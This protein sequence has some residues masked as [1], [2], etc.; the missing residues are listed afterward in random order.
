MI[1]WASDATICHYISLIFSGISFFSSFIALFPQILQTYN[2]KSVEG[3]SFLFLSSWVLGDTVT[4]IGAI[5]TDQLTFQVILA[6]YHLS[7]DLLVCGQYYYYGILYKNQYSGLHKNNRYKFNNNKSSSNFNIFTA[8][9]GFF[10]QITRARA[11]SGTSTPVGNNDKIG[12]ILSWLGA[13]FYV[14][15][16]L[17]QLIKNHKRK[18]T[19]GISPFLFWMIAISNVAYNISILT[20]VEFVMNDNKADFILNELPFIIGNSGTV[21]FDM[22]YFYQHYYLYRGNRNKAVDITEDHEMNVEAGPVFELKE[23]TS[24][25]QKVKSKSRDPI[26]VILQGRDIELTTL[27][28]NDMKIK[29]KI[30]KEEQEINRYK[31]NTNDDNTTE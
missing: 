21:I 7:N 27:N 8:V 1:R 2:D 14:F 4:L 9:V 16:R 25:L 6:M 26:P 13:T 29:N 24:A 19:D 3:L 31:S 15:S 30:E 23:E 12:Y 20:S 18:S 5:L 10:S 22:V 28:S 17:P 11:S